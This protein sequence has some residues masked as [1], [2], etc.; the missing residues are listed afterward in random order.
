MADGSCRSDKTMAIN[1][2]ES[3]SLHILV[4]TTGEVDANTS[5]ALRVAQ[6][7]TD[8]LRGQ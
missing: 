7:K 8:L 3:M 2:R 6:H 5:F 1:L 4:M